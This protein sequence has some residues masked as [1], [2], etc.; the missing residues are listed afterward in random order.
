[1]LYKTTAFLDELISIDYVNFRKVE[2]RFGQ[3][4]S[5]SKDV[6]T[7]ISKKMITK[8]INWYKTLQWEGQSSAIRWNYEIK[9]LLQHKTWAER[10]LSPLQM[11]TIFTKMYEKLKL[12]DKIVFSGSTESEDLC[13]SATVLDA[14]PPRVKM[15]QSIDYKQRQEKVN[16]NKLSFCT[17]E[18]MIMCIHSM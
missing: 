18:L 7:N 8:R 9:N 4:S 3:F 11:A 6:K 15:L 1:M 16:I 13:D 10:K 14:K 5:K 2:D 12:A 17:T